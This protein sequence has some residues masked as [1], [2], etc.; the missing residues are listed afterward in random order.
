MMIM[1]HH[2][3]RWRGLHDT[4]V[5]WWQPGEH[6]KTYNRVCIRLESEVSSELTSNILVYAVGEGVNGAWCGWGRRRLKNEVDQVG[7]AR[8]LKASVHTRAEL[9]D[10]YHC[11]YLWKSDEINGQLFRKM[12]FYVWNTIHK[13][14]K[15]V[16]CITIQFYLAE[17][18]RKEHLKVMKFQKAG[19]WHDLIFI[20]ERALGSSVGW[21]EKRWD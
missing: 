1:K 17:H 10:A 12:F 18:P 6:S 13:I 8:S 3:Y 21:G 15:G 11:L 2:G 19:Q 14:T 7:R 5:R 4:G 16:R 9:V 20:L